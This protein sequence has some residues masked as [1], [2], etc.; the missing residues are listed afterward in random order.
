MNDYPT[1]WQQVF[2]PMGGAL[3]FFGGLGGLVKALAIK[4]TWRETARVMIIGAAT[5]FGL[6]TL[7]P[8][9]LR[10]ML[11]ATAVIPENLGPALGVLC[12]SAFIFGLIATAFVERVIAK[13]EGKSDADET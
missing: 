1:V 13:A 3:A 10:W 7:S 9:M 12:G 11:G 8:P 4:T 2:S 5:A 6:G